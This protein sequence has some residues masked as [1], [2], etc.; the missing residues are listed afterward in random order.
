MTLQRTIAPTKPRQV[1]LHA[2]SAAGGSWSPSYGPLEAVSEVLDVMTRATENL[3][4]SIGRLIGLGG[5][6]NEED[7]AEAR[8]ARR[9]LIRFFT[10]AFA[11]PWVVSTTLRVALFTPAAK[12]F[13][14]PS[15]AF[16]QPTEHQKD[17]MASKCVSLW[18]APVLSLCL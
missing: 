18:S 10:L 9:L 16:V 14:P 2:A 7:D 6:E 3:L 12:A 15:S 8:N 4:Q 17:E 11:L 13:V 5:G 1:L